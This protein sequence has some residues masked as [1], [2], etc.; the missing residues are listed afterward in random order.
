MILEMDQKVSRSVRLAILRSYQNFGRLSTVLDIGSIAGLRA[1]TR[2]F[3]L[4]HITRTVL[5]TLIAEGFHVY[6]DKSGAH[7]SPYCVHVDWRS[8]LKCAR[9]AGRKA[10]RPRN[11]RANTFE[12][13][14]V[15]SIHRTHDLGCMAAEGG[16]NDR[17]HEDI[18]VPG[19]EML[20][21][22]AKLRISPINEE[23]IARSEERSTP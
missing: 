19:L 2:P 4:A 11:V 16:T 9:K 12:E 21:N 22:T 8:A 5:R 15:S 14:M 20:E 23:R 3:S 10:H 13:R 1:L 17:K 7:G 6:R 18:E